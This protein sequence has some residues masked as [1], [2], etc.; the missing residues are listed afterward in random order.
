MT[1]PKYMYLVTYNGVGDL[2][3]AEG[4]LF[5]KGQRLEVPATVAHALGERRDIDVEQIALKDVD[6]DEVAP[7]ALSATPDPQANQPAGAADDGSGERDPAAP[8]PEEEE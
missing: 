2:F 7:P 3:E 6:P 5:P 1:A 4:L 8:D